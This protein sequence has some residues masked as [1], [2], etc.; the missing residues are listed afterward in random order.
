M[1]RKALVVNMLITV[2][3]AI[4][5]FGSASAV[6]AKIFGID[7]QGKQNFFKLNTEL[8]DFAKSNK[9]ISGYMMV[10]DEESFVAKFDAG[11]PLDLLFTRKYD[12]GTGSSFE[13]K[14][15]FS[16]DS[17]PPCGGKDCLVFCKPFSLDYEHGKMT[18]DEPIVI[19]FGD[20]FLLRPFLLIRH[21]AAALETRYLG[22]LVEG[23]SVTEN[24]GISSRRLPVN[25]IKEGE[26]KE[27]KPII[28]I[29]SS[30]IQQSYVNPEKYSTYDAGTKAYTI[31]P[32]SEHFIAGETGKINVMVTVSGGYTINQKG[33]LRLK[34]AQNKNVGMDDKTFDKGFTVTDSSVQFELPLR[35]DSPGTY[36]IHSSITFVYDAP[37]G[38][39]SYLK[40]DQPVEWHVVVF[41]K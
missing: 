38:I 13:V 3:L 20:D 34:F 37:K 31:T 25:L 21:T 27:G 28:S 39:S 9:K 10:L 23:F 17:P 26:S 15:R 6:I 29:S 14:G 33:P 24:S 19:P 8:Q 5:I 7:Q 16:I 40:R 36:D 2:V 32:T 18:C 35:F 41:P 12:K 4:V 30:A 11:K 22:I 1:N